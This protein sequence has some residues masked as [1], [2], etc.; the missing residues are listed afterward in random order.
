MNNKNNINVNKQVLPIINQMT[1]KGMS[2]SV[3][4]D[5]LKKFRECCNDNSIN[6]SDLIEKWI[7]KYLKE[8]EK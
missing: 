6:K 5:V 1:K 8:G 4:E 3:S 2:V 7:V